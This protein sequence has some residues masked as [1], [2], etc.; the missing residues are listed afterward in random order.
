MPQRHSPRWIYIFNI[1]T[2]SQQIIQRGRDTKFHKVLVRNS[3]CFFV[4]LC[5]SG[6][7]NIAATN[8]FKFL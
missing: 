4:P 6:K 5:L 8:Y 7:K 2:V 3:S 1:Y